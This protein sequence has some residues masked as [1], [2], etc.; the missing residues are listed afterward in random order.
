ML[1]STSAVEECKPTKEFEDKLKSQCPD[2]TLLTDLNGWNKHDV[3][4]STTGKCDCTDGETDLGVKGKSQI[5]LRY[6]WP[7]TQSIRSTSSKI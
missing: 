5:Y 7:V 1:R 6:H 2:K 4:H 3:G